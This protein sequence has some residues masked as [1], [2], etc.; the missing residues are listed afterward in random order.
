MK[1]ILRSIT[2]AVS[3]LLAACVASTA[4]A[5]AYVGSSAELW[6]NGI[7]PYEWS[8]DFIEDNKQKVLDAMA[9]WESVANVDF[10]PRNGED[11]YLLIS[12]AG[13][14][15]GSNAEVGFGEGGQRRLNIREDWTNWSAVGITY[16]LAHEVGHVLGLHHT[17]QR[18]DRETYVDVVYERIHDCKFG[19]F[20]AEPGSLGWPRDDMDFDSIMSYGQCIFSACTYNFDPD[21]ECG[22]DECPRWESK[23]CDEESCCSDDPD[24]CSSLDIL[25]PNES[26]Q[27]GMGQRNHLSEIDIQTMSF[28]Y[29]PSNW[30]FLERDNVSLFSLGTFHHPFKTLQT[31]SLFSPSDAIV[32]TVPGDYDNSSG[33]YDKSLLLKPTHGTV[34][35]R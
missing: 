18:P 23:D 32:W 9:V 21:C 19:N 7:V 34:V 16:G 8:G 13:A 26:W 5:G 11:D 4:H 1:K 31:A 14:D 17:H 25:P 12:N 29:P 10:V 20:D 30:R 22:D 15:A 35:L 2:T 3:V 24:N 33:V 27:A 6:P 28:M